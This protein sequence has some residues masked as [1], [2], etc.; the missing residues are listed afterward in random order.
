LTTRIFVIVTKLNAA[1]FLAGTGRLLE[2][3]CNVAFRSLLLLLLFLLVCGCTGNQALRP[4]AKSCDVSRNQ[5]C[6]YHSIEERQ[7]PKSRAPYLVSFVEFDD[8]GDLQKPEQ[9]TV[10]FKKLEAEASVHDIGLILYVHGWKRNAGAD[11]ADVALFHE[12][13]AGIAGL[14]AQRSPGAARPPKIVGIYAG[15]RGQGLR[16]GD[17]AETLTTFWSRKNAAH[18]VADGSIRE[19]F[20][21]ARGFVKQTTDRY[22]SSDTRLLTIGH[23]FGGLIVY[24]A[25]SQY[26]LE[27]AINPDKDRQVAGYGNLVLI[28]NPAI[29]AQKYALIHEAMQRM[30]EMAPHQR[31]V[32][33]AITSE[34]DWATGYTF[35][36]GRT[37][38]TILEPKKHGEQT[39]RT[40]TALGHYLPYATHRLHAEGSGHAAP[41]RLPEARLECEALADFESANRRDGMLQPGWRRRYDNG[42]VLTHQIEQGIQGPYHPNAPYWIIRADATVLDGHSLRDVTAEK[43]N[44]VLQGFVRQLYDDLVLD[45]GRVRANGRMDCSRAG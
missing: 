3:M 39:V 32:F 10:L 9:M 27:N 33:V 5:D 12:L 16:L 19:L 38:N 13:I 14:E 6:Q 11:D 28:I 37:L 17:A 8:Q 36:I 26:L 2:N 41:G 1:S 23:S 30:P 35:P 45:T 44:L 24:S 20:A 22:T 34:T 40:R 31:P 7:A 21:R 43:P 18:R 25:L 4:I 42:A 29:E 15:W